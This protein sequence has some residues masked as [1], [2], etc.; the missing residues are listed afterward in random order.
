[1]V[2][3]QGSHQCSGYDSDPSSGDVVSK[4]YVYFAGSSASWDG[5]QGREPPDWL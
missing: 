4:F 3:E 5:M 1:M 2:M